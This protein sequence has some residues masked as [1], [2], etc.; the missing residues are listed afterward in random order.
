[1]YLI[2]FSFILFI[3]NILQYLYSIIDIIFI[4]HL[5]G[6]NGVIALGN[7]ASIMFIITSVSLGLSIG[8]SVII[9]KYKGADDN[10][11]YKQSIGNLLFLSSSLALIISIIG[12]IFS[13]HILL[14]M[15][16]PKESFKYADDYIKI[17][18][19]GTF[20]IFLYSS[21]S[22][23]IKSSGREKTSLY[24]IIIAALLN[25]LLNF[26]FCYILKLS[27][28][29]AALATVIS[30]AV[31]FLLSLYYTRK[32]LTF[33]FNIKIIKE[34]IFI[35]LPCIFQMLIINISYFFVNI[36]MNK[37]NVLAGFTIG[38]KIN[39]FIGM[40]SW[41]IGEALSIIVSKST[42]EKDYI[43][44]KS[45]VKFAIFLNIAATVTAVIF[46]HLFVKNIISIFYSGDEK[47]INDIILYLQVCASFNCLTYALMYVLDSFL[48][49]IQKSYLA[50]VNSFIDS[51]IFKVIISKILEIYMCYLG[52]YIA[53]ALSSIV[54]AL[55]GLIYFY[56]FIRKI[57]YNKLH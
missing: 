17:I 27:V 20:F 46:I 33:N 39:T 54:P 22:S 2:K 12:L 37:Y 53:M 13:R 25:F 6:D 34:L 1:M 11:K 56:M 16:I 9:S 31:S 41:S 8:G 10:I 44:I 52:I 40:I 23:V 36:M 32:L 50:F 29:G 3:S 48:I 19:S 24:F 42:G 38:L 15:N 49:G 18:F 35:S 7:C 5:V 26:L 45:T 47:V 21:L 30:Q 14:F 55:I 43:K 28:K 51:I 4:S 57:N